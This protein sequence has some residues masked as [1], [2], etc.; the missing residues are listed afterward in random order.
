MYRALIVD[1]ED[2]IKIGLKT[3]IDWEQLGFEIVGTAEDGLEAIKMVE[4]LSPDLIITDIIMPRM[5][6]IELME[7]LKKRGFA[8]KIIVLSNY[9]E[10]DYVKRA[11]KLGAEDYILKVAYS[12]EEFAA[13]L[14]KMAALLG[15]SGKGR[16]EDRDDIRPKEILHQESMSVFG[17]LFLI[18]LPE[19]I[20]KFTDMEY[21]KFVRKIRIVLE[22]VL[23]G[24]KKLE[25]D[26]VKKTHIK[27][28]FQTGQERLP[29]DS[30]I[31]ARID[32]TLAL[33][34][35][36]KCSV[37]Y[38]MNNYGERE[39]MEAYERCWDKAGAAF[40]GPL[41]AAEEDILFEKISDIFD[42]ISVTN[43]YRGYI[44]DWKFEKMQ[45]EIQSIVLNFQ[46]K[47]VD[48]F[49]VKDFIRQIIIAVQLYF[50]ETYHIEVLDGYRSQI[51]ECQQISE[52]LLMINHSMDE[53]N[54]RI[55]EISWQKEDL[56]LTEKI[57]KYIQ[58]N[59]DHKLTL[60]EL[61][62]YVNF[63]PNYISGYFKQKTG[64]T[65]SFYINNQ[66]MIYAKKLL[67]GGQY[68]IKEISEMVGYDDAF[69][70]SRCF[71]RYF[72]YSPKN[73]P[74]NDL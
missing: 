49:E 58:K 37:I 8:G 15:E 59:I 73:L 50:D 19:H 66:K 71:K 28:T 30:S 2:I 40:Y 27:V 67:D 45:D 74:N 42:F 38:K 70:F 62:D 64:Q 46:E 6:G 1:D 34:L 25:I 23:E 9:G 65:L 72:G 4:E 41:V 63:N 51:H 31:P 32:K 53:I 52:L 26:F 10:V 48:P 56:E 7:E 17:H 24:R 54:K 33:Y 68:K 39:M 3:I 36:L 61:A 22:Q 35:M 13:L 11:M 69:Y 55:M 43:R 60:N 14:K 57:K 20:Q 44:R 12:K 21:E 29:E 18:V 5:D 47:M 16:A